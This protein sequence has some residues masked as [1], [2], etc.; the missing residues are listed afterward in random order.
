[1]DVTLRKRFQRISNFHPFVKISH[2]RSTSTDTHFDCEGE[3]P[4]DI[5]QHIKELAFSST[6][7]H[8][9]SN[10]R[11]NAL[12]QLYQCTLSSSGGE[13]RGAKQ[14]AVL[15]LPP[16]AT[17]RN[18]IAY[19]R[20]TNRWYPCLA[21]PTPVLGLSPQATKVDSSLIRLLWELLP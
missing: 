19:R 11:S 10:T 15:L 21:P 17:R 6:L 14:P 4:H 18:S 20:P 1:M 5:Q 12:W 3:A 7:F 16:Q 9:A 2:P 13:A 8:I